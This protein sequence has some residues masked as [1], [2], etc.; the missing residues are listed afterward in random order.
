MPARDVPR[1]GAVCE[2][3]A[4]RTPWRG[5]KHACY[6][7]SRAASAALALS[8]VVHRSLKTFARIDRFL[9]VSEFVRGKYVEAGI[10]AARVTVKPNFTWPSNA[11]PG[12]AVLSS[13][14]AV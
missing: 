10:A 11:A 4:G 5:V 1:D 8:L 7:D 12:S 3:C 2:D 9:A 13:S 14:S 6:R